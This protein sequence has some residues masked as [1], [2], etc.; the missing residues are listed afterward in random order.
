MPPPCCDCLLLLYVVIIPQAKKRGGHLA[1]SLPLSVAE[2]LLQLNGF[3]EKNVV[4]Q[5]NMPV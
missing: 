1:A 5:M 4:L 3:R 2:C